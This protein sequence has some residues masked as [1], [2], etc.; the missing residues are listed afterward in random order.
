MNKKNRFSLEV[1]K[2]EIS[3]IHAPL[4]DRLTDGHW[5]LVFAIVSEKYVI[6]ILM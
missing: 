5:Y 2:T 3:H 4:C 6:K 1:H